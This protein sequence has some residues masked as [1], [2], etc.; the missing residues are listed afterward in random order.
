MSAIFNYFKN[1]YNLCTDEEIFNELLNANINSTYSSQI[2]LHTL[3]SS[4]ELTSDQLRKIYFKIQQMLNVNRCSYFISAIIS[5]NNCPNIVLN[6]AFNFVKITTENLNDNSE[7]IYNILKSPN[8]DEGL[9]RKIKEFVD[10]HIFCGNYDNMIC[11][12]V[13][14]N[15][16]LTAQDLEKYYDNI[17]E[18]GPMH[19][20]TSLTRYSYVLS[21]PNC[22]L[23]VLNSS[24]KKA[25]YTGDKF[26]YSLLCSNPKCP[27]DFLDYMYEY[28][29]ANALL[30]PNYPIE[31][32][33]IMQRSI[34]SSTP[35]EF[36]RDYRIEKKKLFNYGDNYSDEKILQIYGI[37]SK[38][39]RVFIIEN[40]VKSSSLLESI[41]NRY[42]NEMSYEENSAIAKSSYIYD[43]LINKLFARY[44][45]MF[46]NYNYNIFSSFL[47]NPRCSEEMLEQNYNN[48]SLTGKKVILKNFNCPIKLLLNLLKTGYSDYF[49]TKSD[50]IN[51]IINNNHFTLYT[52]VELEE[53]IK[54]AIE[55]DN[56]IKNLLA[57]KII[58]LLTSKES[59]ENL[60]DETI[61]VA[62]KYC[63]FNIN[64]ICKNL[65][66]IQKIRIFKGKV[67]SAFGF[68]NQTS[69]SDAP[70]DEIKQE[71]VPK[72]QNEKSKEANKI[73]KSILELSRF[74]YREETL[75]EI[76]IKLKDNYNKGV[77]EYY[78]KVNDKKSIELALTN[79]LQKKNP[80]EL[81]N[82]FISELNKILY[83]LQE[84]Q[85]IYQKYEELLNYIERCLYLL[86][87]N[88]NNNSLDNIMH[89][90]SSLKYII[91][92]YLQDNTWLEKLKEIFISEKDSIN[93]Y[94][95]DNS[96]ELNYSSL[97]EFKTHIRSK[98][99]L[100]TLM[101]KSAA[102]NKFDV[103]LIK[104]QFLEES[105][106]NI[107][108][109]QNKYINKRINEIE[110]IIEYINLN[111][112]E[113]EK[114]EMQI[115]LGDSSLIDNS[116]S[117][118]ELNNLYGKLAVIQGVIQTRLDDI[119]DLSFEDNGPSR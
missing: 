70:V 49:A 73:V 18:K 118:D 60:T 81:F 72:S 64:R 2:F 80:D 53:D 14:S 1:K 37:V 85:K 106:N 48:V 42:R 10:E 13:Y 38:S 62:S 97:D 65:D 99:L 115:L 94:L 92:N 19:V 54:N 45:N 114:K 87:S 76:I 31:K 100:F 96:K 117:L 40:F 30:H 89:D 34:K 41:Y 108:D 51:T 91:L 25:A 32:I 59:E 78:K 28:G 67:G 98:L 26:F 103:N 86:N 95:K 69:E 43:S 90:I 79:E 84:N 4:D 29:F 35:D 110:N 107:E 63:D 102:D 111:G 8:I 50:L 44:F 101:I 9:F 47:S 71:E 17:F 20:I 22:S 56:S 21:N 46:G 55:N 23:E 74:Y 57:N 93:S 7:I 5:N 11:K 3:L 52:L 39:N 75:Q 88:I 82:T 6:S 119:I 77:E 24:N 104:L 109:A 112:N 33:E 116:N 68:K 83:E 58:S 16:L 61:Q 66:R 12:L 15:P 105:K 113:L 27:P 36:A